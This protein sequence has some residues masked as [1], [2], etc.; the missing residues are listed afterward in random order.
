MNVTFSLTLCV[1]S[2]LNKTQSNLICVACEAS[3][4]LK[5]QLCFKWS[6]QDCFLCFLFLCQGMLTVVLLDL[7]SLFT[8][9]GAQVAPLPASYENVLTT[10]NFLWRSDQLLA[11]RCKYSH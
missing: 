4:D 5:E 10:H 3:V 2:L 11:L 9:P 7:V 6:F 1:K 8:M